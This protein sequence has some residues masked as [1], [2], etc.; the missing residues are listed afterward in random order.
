MNVFRLPFGNIFLHLRIGQPKHKL[1]ESFRTFF[2]VDST[3]EYTHEFFLKLC[4]WLVWLLN[5]STYFAAKNVIGL[6]HV[7]TVIQSGEYIF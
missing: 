1:F 2:S 7:E 3:G 6:R 4:H 5:R